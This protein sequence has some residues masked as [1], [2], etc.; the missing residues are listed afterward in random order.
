MREILQSAPSVE[1]RKIK[2]P[3]LGDYD[4]R[5]LEREIKREFCSAIERLIVRRQWTQRVAAVRLGTS[6]ANI[7]RICN[8]NVNSLTAG[9]L[10]RILVRASTPFTRVIVS[11]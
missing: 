10:L 4:N 7:S 11:I 5:E 3:V 1:N 6:Q 2:R 9:M 8:K